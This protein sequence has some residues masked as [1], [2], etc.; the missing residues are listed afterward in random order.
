MKA[1][2]TGFVNAGF[3]AAC[4]RDNYQYQR[5]QL[6]M[7]RPIWYPAFPADVSM[8]GQIGDAVQKINLAYPDYLTPEKVFE[9]TGV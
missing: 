9:L 8:L 6:Y 2:G 5:S 3:L 7:T 1:F 4:V